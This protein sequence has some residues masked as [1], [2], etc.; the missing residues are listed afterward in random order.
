M[1]LIDELAQQGITQEDLE[2]AA[3]VRLFAAD[4]AAEGIDLSQHDEETVETLYATWLGLREDE[5][6]VKQASFEDEARDEARAKLAEAE[7]I[8]RYMARVYVDE[9]EK[10][11]GARETLSAAG[12][13]ALTIAGELPGVGE[14]RRGT[15]KLRNAHSAHKAGRRAAEFGEKHKGT[16]YIG[17]AISAAANKTK[18]GTDMVRNALGKSGLR[19]LARGGAKAGATMT[20]AGL[21][22]KGLMGEKKASGLSDFDTLVADRIDE[23]IGSPEPTLEDA[24]D[25]AALEV[26]AAHGYTFE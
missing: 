9:L 25:A 1:S 22:G 6:E 19:D 20:V 24:V 11:A 14:L 2:K 4:A 12:K 5:G 18:S 16:P 23:L 13:R 8:G 3:S 15:G 17:G 26:L 21:A 10:Q 7:Y